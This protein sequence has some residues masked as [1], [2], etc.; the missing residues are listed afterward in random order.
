LR[1]N[2]LINVAFFNDVTGS[3]T[4]ETQPMNCCAKLILYKKILSRFSNIVNWAFLEQAKSATHAQRCNLRNLSHPV[5]TRSR[6]VACFEAVSRL[7]NAST[8]V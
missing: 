8:E 1:S 7:A 6:G 2:E 5:C 3:D 4:I